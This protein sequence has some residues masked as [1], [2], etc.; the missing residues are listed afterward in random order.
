MVLDLDYPEYCDFFFDELHGLMID[1]ENLGKMLESRISTLMKE[2]EKMIID[3]ESCQMINRDIHAAIEAYSRA[4]QA[5]CEKLKIKY[6]SSFERIKY[7][8]DQK[9]KYCEIHSL[10]EKG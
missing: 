4:L 6:T 10:D 1:S 7:R 9:R 3:E 5:Y 2:F 8:S